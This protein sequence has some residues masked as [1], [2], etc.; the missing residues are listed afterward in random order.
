M[1]IALATNKKASLCYK[2]AV[3]IVDEALIC[4][5]E[6][7]AENLFNRALRLALKC[8]RSDGTNAEYKYLAGYIYYG[9]PNKTDDSWRLAESFLKEALAVNS[10]H[11]FAHYYL[12][13]LYFDRKRYS[14]ALDVLN[15]LDDNYFIAMDQRWRT[16]KTME[17]RLC[18]KL[19]LSAAGSPVD[20]AKALYQ[21]HRSFEDPL[22]APVPKE[23]GDCLNYIERTRALDDRAL[24]KMRRYF[25]RIVEITEYEI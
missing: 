9:K 23:L 5:N 19:Y 12:G 20:E 10:T 7:R 6:A 21:F 8:C 18:C 1:A 4:P 15:D 11:P 24:V 2:K 22:L 25:E 13:C 3:S 14:N 16:A 17:L